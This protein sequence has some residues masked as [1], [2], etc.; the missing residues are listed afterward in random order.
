MLL[1]YLLSQFQIS[2][3]GLSPSLVTLSRVFNYLRLMLY[4]K[5]HN[6]RTNFLAKIC[7]GLGCS[8]F[9]RR[10]WGNLFWFLFLALLRCFSSGCTLSDTMYSYR[11]VRRYV[12]LVILFGNLRIK[13]FWQLPE[14]Y[15]SLIRPS[16]VLSTKAST[17]CINVEI[18][19]G[20]F[21]RSNFA[22]QNLRGAIWPSY[23]SPTFCRGG[24][25]PYSHFKVQSRLNRD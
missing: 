6:P 18:L 2:F 21:T 1:G 22:K 10:Y 14:A 23:T 16:S 5:P 8:L 19:F 24:F 11:T 3:T 7:A 17:V 25:H 15:R 13:A 4:R 12:G 20:F 9:A